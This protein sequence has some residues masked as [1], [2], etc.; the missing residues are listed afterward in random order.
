M[1]IDHST[2]SRRARHWNLVVLALVLLAGLLTGCGV[3][4]GTVE[5]VDDAVKLLQDIERNGIWSIT[6][7]G[8]DALAEQNSYVATLQVEATMPEAGS[9]TAFSHL[10]LTVT[11]DADGN[12]RYTLEQ[13]DQST[14]YTQYRAPDP[15]D[16]SAPSPAGV[17]RED[18]GY[19]TCADAV[20]QRL[21][22]RGLSSVFEVYALDAIGAR[23]LAV[24]EKDGDSTIAERDATHYTIETR[25][26]DALEILERAEDRALRDQIEATEA[27]TLS[28]S[29]DLDN[30]T[31]A[32]L[33]L[34]ISYANA[35]GGEQLALVFDVTRWGDTPG[36]TL[37]AG[38]SITLCD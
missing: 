24:V 28:G 3:D 35:T 21:L 11:V 1:T 12:T 8:L 2:P 10:A 37:P 36:I 18:N 15:A 29:L 6:E 9:A 5:T 34:D 16:N 23:T 17:Y 7:D 25:L 14:R 19:Y 31:G 32:L 4:S 20:I 22:G 26:D 33:H 30:A 27:A 13:G 38:E